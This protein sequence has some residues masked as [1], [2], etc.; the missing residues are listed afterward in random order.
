[1]GKAILKSGFDYMAGN[2]SFKMD[3][4][5]Y[6]TGIYFV[7]VVTSNG[8]TQITKLIVGSDK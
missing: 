5:E 2:N 6:K 1:M 7:N 3:V 8:S 4:N